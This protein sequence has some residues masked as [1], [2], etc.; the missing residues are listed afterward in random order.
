MK[1]SLSNKVLSTI[2]RFNMFQDG[3]S[4]LI[5]ISGG[6]DSVFLTQALNQ[7]KASYN[8]KLYC[9]HLDHKTRNGQSSKDAEFVRNFCDSIG[10]ELFKAEIDIKNWCRQNRFSFQDG[11]RRVRLDLLN[12]TAAKHRIKKIAT[13]HTADD[14]VETF[15]MHLLRGSGLRGLSGIQPVNG[16]FIRPMLEIFHADILDYLAENEI[17]YCTDKTNQEN[18]YYRNK[19][20]NVLIPFI[21]DNFSK[22]LVKNLSG[23][24]DVIRQENDFIDAY[25]FKCLKKIAE[26]TPGKTAPISDKTAKVSDKTAGVPATPGTPGINAVTA[27]AGTAGVKSDSRNDS[28]DIKGNFVMGKTQ[29]SAEI[30]K[31]P[32]V[33]LRAHPESVIKRIIISAIELLGKD[34]TDIRRENLSDITKLC[35]WGNERKE[36]ILAGGITIIRECG[37]LYLYSGVYT[38]QAVQAAPAASAAQTTQAAQTAEA[39][40]TAPAAQTAQTMPAVS[41]TKTAQTART[42]PAALAAQTAQT[43][44]AVTAASATQTAQT[45]RTAPA[46]PAAQTAQTAPA[47]ESSACLCPDIKIEIGSKQ[48]LEIVG[49]KYFIEAFLGGMD[50]LRDKNIKSSEAYLDF[51]KIRFPLKV[52]YWQ[53]AGERFIPLGLKNSKKIQDYFIDMKIPYSKRLRIPLFNDREKIIWVGNYRID[54]RVKIDGQTK[55]IFHIKIIEI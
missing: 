12:E 42:A 25:G 55:K 51:D 7:I 39:A 10:L 40:Q 48:E 35:F 1:A 16:R 53:K 46:A 18:I 27:I 28:K 6:P 2:S 17:P 13:G 38:A 44:P 52:K 32:I 30:I 54:E 29:M 4:V 26:I 47:A 19:V 43:A 37:I 20:R 15:L 8:L 49:R 45:A 50:I 3:D 5:S 11:A 33:K 41:A 9:F 31:I 34:F 23:T 14:N 22:N 21:N 24:I 36:L